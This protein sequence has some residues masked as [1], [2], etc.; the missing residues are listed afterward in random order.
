MY[1]LRI[2]V[3]HV[4]IIEANILLDHILEHMIT[5]LVLNK[6]GADEIL[7]GQVDQ[8]L[9]PNSIPVLTRKDTLG[10]YSYATNRDCVLQELVNRNDHGTGSHVEPAARRTATFIFHI[11][12]RDCTCC[13]Q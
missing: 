6:L 13:I 11:L 9:G 8:T 2:F 4:L 5:E 3:S 7:I 12:I 1:L 10:K